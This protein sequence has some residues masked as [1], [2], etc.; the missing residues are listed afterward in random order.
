MLFAATLVCLLLQTPAGIKFDSP[1]GWVSKA[2]SSSMRVADWTL[3]KADGDQDDAMVTLYYFGAGG[4]GGLQANIDRWIGQMTQ[5]DGKPSKA[6]AT[7]ATLASTS[8]LKI[9]TVDIPGTYVA[10]VTPGSAER[11][12]KPGYR[13]ITALI[14][15]A[16]GAHYVKFVGPAK[17]VARWSQSFETFL[18]SLRQ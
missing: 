17:T 18:K 11:F 13:M 2:P 12:N 14:E 15:T 4:G 16:G 5:P 8:G 9:T 7:T 6:V 3:P 10:E 1:A